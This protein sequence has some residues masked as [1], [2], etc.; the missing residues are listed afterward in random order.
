MHRALLV[1][2]KGPHRSAAGFARDRRR[3]RDEVRL[4]A[5]AET[6]AQ[7]EH[8]DIHLGHREVKHLGE[9]E[10]RRYGGLRADADG[11]RAG[12]RGAAVADFADHVALVALERLDNL[13]QDVGAGRLC[14]CAVVLHHHL[15][16]GGLLRVVGGAGN[17]HHAAGAALQRTHP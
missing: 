9:R 11:R 2:P 16:L 15:R 8:L 4:S 3:L 6:A 7:A 5:P 12:Q 10:L 17:H 1:R 13:P 14:R